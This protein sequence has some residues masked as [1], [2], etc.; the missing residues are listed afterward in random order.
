MTPATDPPPPVLVSEADLRAAVRAGLLADNQIDPL[1]AHLRQA[2]LGQGGGTVVRSAADGPSA[3]PAHE[4]PRFGFTHLLYYFGGLLAIGAATLFLTEAFQRLGAWA[5]LAISL[6]YLGACTVA[7]QRL[8]ARGL[9]IPAGILATLAVCLVPLA[10]WA[11]Q[12]GL[13]WWPEGGAGD[14][15]Q[16]RQFHT[17]IDFRWLTL[18]LVTLAAAVVA[19]WALRHPFLML[20]V[21]ITLWYM[22][23]DLARLIVAPPDSSAAWDFYRDFSMGFGGLMVLLAIWIDARSRAPG[24]SGR[25]YPFWLYLL[26]MLTFWGALSARQSDSELDKLVYGL[27]NLGF[28]L[29]GVLLQR[30]VFTVLGGLGV[31]AYLGHLSWQVFKDSLLFPLA[32]TLIGLGVIALGVWWQRN[33]AR[34][35]AALRQR[36]P[37]AWLRWLPPG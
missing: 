34:W 4:A 36:L 3:R 26:G 5:L 13:G 15:G 6:A 28:V 23:M 25:D 9:G 37:A 32:L 21:A 30:R 17:H 7:S 24:G 20:P 10:T 33:E 18:E 19:L 31:A 27:L 14:A 2:A 1:W 8:Q 16:Y 29:L 35:Q 11:L 22:S 12:H